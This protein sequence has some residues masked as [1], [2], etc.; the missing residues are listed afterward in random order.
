MKFYILIVLLFLNTSLFY[1]NNENQW[2][3]TAGYNAIDLYPTGIKKNIPFYPQGKVY[4][5]FLPNP[6]QVGLEVIGEN[7]GDNLGFSVALNEKGDIMAVGSPK[8]GAATKGRVKVLKYNSVT[9]TWADFGNSI[10]VLWGNEGDGVVELTEINDF[11]C[12]TT[13]ILEINISDESTSIDELT[14]SKT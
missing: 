1:Q 6:S 8:F 4:E 13:N 12:S 3:I 11:G 2:I 9:N 10:E 5:D 7:A 14:K